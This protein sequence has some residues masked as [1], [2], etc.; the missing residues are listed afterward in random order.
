MTEIDIIYF[1]KSATARYV[2]SSTDTVCL[3]FQEK[4]SMVI[5]FPTMPFTVTN[6]VGTT[7]DMRRVT[8]F[9]CSSLRKS[10]SILIL[11]GK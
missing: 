9:V 10:L 11:I 2:L 7:D 1:T 8:T 6:A 3:E 5:K 4:S